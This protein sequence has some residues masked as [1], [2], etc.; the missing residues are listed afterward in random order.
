MSLRR[1][2]QVP[3]EKCARMETLLITGALGT[4]GR[5]TVDALAD[6][7]EIVAVDLGRPD[8]SPYDTVEYIG[9]DLTDQGAAWELASHVEPD[10]VVHLAAVPGAGH[11]PPTETFQTNVMSTYN[12]LSAAGEVG[13]D[14]V[15]TS[16]EASYG[17]TAYGEAGPVDYLPIDEAHPQRAAE[18]YGFSKIVGE[19]IAERT[20]RYYGTA[21]TS[22]R[23]SW[24]REPGEYNTERVRE[25]FDLDDPDPSGSIWSYVDVQDV[26][27]L[28]EAALVADT[29]GHEAYIA[30]AADNYI[31]VPTAD[32]F[33]AAWGELPEDCSVSGDDAAFSTA[34]AQEELG[35]EPQH[36]WRDAATAAVEG[37]R[38]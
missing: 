33:E 18:A 12:V 2:A 31:D 10:A 3:S 22:I 17:V 26:V 5:W 29:S 15:W 38:L 13:A 16:S 30:A 19:L 11:R 35:W 6:D 27:S 20:V 25:S 23:P 7:Y 21:V 1:C 24:V 9:A 37:P 32:A 14:V 8:K 28:I 4:I 36:S 34:K